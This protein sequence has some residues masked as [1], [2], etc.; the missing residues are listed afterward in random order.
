MV[1]VLLVF[2]ATA[3]AFG[4][5]LHFGRGFWLR[6]R[7]VER[8]Q[9]ALGTLADITQ[10]PEPAEEPRP[11]AVGHQA[12]V[13]VIGPSGS[14][15]A[16]R[17]ALPPPRLF[18]SSSQGS[19]SPLRRPGRNTPSAAAMDAVTSSAASGRSSNARLVR[20]RL[21]QVPAPM[22]GPRAPGPSRLLAPGTGGDQDAG[23]LEREPAM[24]PG[25]SEEPTLPAVLP[26]PPV[27]AGEPPTRPVPMVRPHVFY[28]DDI[29]ARREVDDAVAG[30]VADVPLPVL[31]S[32]ASAGEVPAS[33]PSGLGPNTVVEPTGHSHGGS[34][35]RLHPTGLRLAA[36][37][38]AVVAVAAAVTVIALSGSAAPNGAG[39]AVP[40]TRP[41][42]AGAARSTPSSARSRTTL[43]HRQRPSKSAAATLPPR[44]TPATTA[45]TAKPAVLL[46]ASAGT[47]TYQLKSPSA[48]IVVKAS[49]PC[50][51]EV[52]A[53][54]AAGTVVY[55]GTLE[56]GQQSSITGPAWIRL[57]DPPYVAVTVNGKQM[58]VP[59]ARTAVPLDL[60][61]TLG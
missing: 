55:E 57:G 3:C 35:G 26:P 44:R 11:P 34:R 18:A 56:K 38:A 16:D 1:L 48:S 2:L 22:A 7:S 39:Q 61:F 12:H 14:T 49:G 21:P 50:W 54:G 47:A 4:S 33:P 45:T 60:Q 13:R 23:G 8:H 53:R 46:S 58:S 42:P 17:A 24:A 5:A 59:G 28:F 41:R 51:I 43:G 25:P 9:Q 20:T 52:K 15:T 27:A 37:G 19:P 31:S 36:A 29:T 32:A 40:P 6:A 30:L 10:N